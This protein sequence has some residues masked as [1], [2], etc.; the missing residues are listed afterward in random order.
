MLCHTFIIKYQILNVLLCS[1]KG[2]GVL[3]TWSNIFS[4]SMLLQFYLLFKIFWLLYLNWNETNNE[5]DTVRQIC[6]LSYIHLTV[7]HNTKRGTGVSS[8]SFKWKQSG[9]CSKYWNWFNWCSRQYLDIEQS[10]FSLSMLVNKYA[11]ELEV[12]QYSS[13]LDHSNTLWLKKF[14]FGRIL[15][16]SVS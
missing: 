14:Y 13:D 16:A 3:I 10:E 5:P 7:I 6:N 11:V 1:L 12:L 9:S 8:Y 15:Y 2:G 4:L